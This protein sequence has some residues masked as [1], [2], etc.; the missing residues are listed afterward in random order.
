MTSSRA[1]RDHNTRHRGLVGDVTSL[2]DTG[3]DLTDKL[4]LLAVAIE[5]SQA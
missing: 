3:R 5:I 2:L 1:L 4:R